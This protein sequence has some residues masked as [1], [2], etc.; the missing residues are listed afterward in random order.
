[1]DRSQIA[2]LQF[3]TGNKIILDEHSH[4]A[5]MRN[6]NSITCIVAIG[7]YNEVVQSL[8]VIKKLLVKKIYSII[9]IIFVLMQSVK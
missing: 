3:A 1:M 2:W 9:L 6:D 7:K 4:N 8:Y 5:Q